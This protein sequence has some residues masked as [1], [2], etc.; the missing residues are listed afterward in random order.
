M[1]ALS[2][3]VLAE[4]AIL[5]QLRGALLVIGSTMPPMVAIDIFDD[6]DAGIGRFSSP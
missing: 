5:S 6:Y 3:F 1:T 2:L 4:H